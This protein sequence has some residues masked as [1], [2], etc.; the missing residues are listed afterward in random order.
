LMGPPDKIVMQRGK[1]DEAVVTYLYITQY[2][3]TYTTRGW[4]RDNYTPF[5]FVNDRL[6]GWGWHHL[7]AAAERY[8]FDIR[9]TP[10]L[11]PRP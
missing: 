5:I 7:D 3:E 8:G 4:D 2:T 9:T 11:A 10:F 1:N 6:T